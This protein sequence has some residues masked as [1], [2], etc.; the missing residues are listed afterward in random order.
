MVV[1]KFKNF[2]SDWKH[3]KRSLE[4]IVRETKPLYLAERG[5]PRREWPC[6]FVVVEL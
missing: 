1:R 5:N 2:N 4:E 3:R 6:E